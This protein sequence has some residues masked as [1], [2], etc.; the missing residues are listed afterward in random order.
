[1]GERMRIAATELLEVFFVQSEHAVFGGVAV[2][3]AHLLQVRADDRGAAEAD[4]DVG[5]LPLRLDLREDLVPVRPAV[6]H[7]DVLQAV[8][9]GGGRLHH[10][11]LLV[12]CHSDYTK[13][14]CLQ[15]SVV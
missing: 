15:Y 10:F 4:A 8:L 9:G 1:M 13:L 2:L 3:L 7:P 14:V 11:D 5:V 6:P 12:G